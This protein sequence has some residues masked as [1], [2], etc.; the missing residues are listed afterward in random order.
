LIRVTCVLVLG[1]FDL[2]HPGHVQFLEQAA[3]FGDELWV[4]LNPD[5]FV[6]RYKRPPILTYEE[7]ATML[8]ALS[9]VDH[10][11]PNFGAED[12]K[13]AIIHARKHTLEPMVIV[14]GDDWTGESYLRQLQVTEEWLTDRDIRIEYVPYTASISTTDLIE[15][16][17]A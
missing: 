16:C 14:H 1:T 6:R 10:V 17:R 2:L 9:V 5:D 12:S 15:R 13:P 11:F 8:R 3:V 7:R 4:A